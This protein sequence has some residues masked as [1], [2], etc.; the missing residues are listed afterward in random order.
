MRIGSDLEELRFSMEPSMP[1]DLNKP[2]PPDGDYYQVDRRLTILETRFDTILPTLATKADLIEL[3]SQLKTILITMI[4]GF[5]TLSVA[6]I[7][8]AV[9][10]ANLLRH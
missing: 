1:S 6:T 7:G 5:A 2:T 4:L 10:V 9:S 8:V 3:K